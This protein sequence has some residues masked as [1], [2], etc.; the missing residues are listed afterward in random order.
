[1]NIL[2]TFM[3]SKSMNISTNYQLITVIY[4]LAFGWCVSLLGLLQL[5]IWAIYA[6]LR[7]K[8]K[9]WPMVRKFFCEMMP[10]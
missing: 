9:S 8:D 3:V 6:I 5:P 1:M 7:Q 4:F 2:Q 10:F